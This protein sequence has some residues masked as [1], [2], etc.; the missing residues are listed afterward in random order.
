MRYPIQVFMF[1][2]RLSFN[3]SSNVKR[4]EE[5]SK[6]SHFPFPGDKTL[7]PLLPLWDWPS[8][9]QLLDC[10]WFVARFSVFLGWFHVLGIHGLG[11]FCIFSKPRADK[12]VSLFLA[13][14][15]LA[16]LDLA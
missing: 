9:T 8:G 10:G 7:S 4:G 6:R 16:C 11:L 2:I 5:S 12:T 13:W 1:P 14:L 15:G 3:C